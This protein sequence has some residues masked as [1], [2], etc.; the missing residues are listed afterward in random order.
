RPD[1]PAADIKAWNPKGIILS[2]GPA[3]VEQKGAPMCDPALFELGVP[4]LGICYGLQLMAKLLGGRVAASP[5]REFGPARVDIVEAAG[6]FSTLA[7]G[8]TTDVWMSHGDKVE[9]LPA[10]FRAIGTTPS[11]QF[12]AIAHATKL[13][14]GLQFHPE[15]VHTKEGVLMLRAF[16]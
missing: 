9:A 15:V 13:Q 8:A 14:F 3:S 6:P 4:V 5:H 16:L 12:A 7:R 11:S 10:G 1:L 2:G